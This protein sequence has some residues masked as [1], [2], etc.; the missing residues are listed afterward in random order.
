MHLKRWITG[1]VGAPLIVLLVSFGGPFLFAVV[2][3]ILCLLA[4]WEY[5]RIVFQDRDPSN[6]GLIP[7]SGFV[8][9]PF[10][11]WGSYVNSFKIVLG[12]L[13]INFIITALISLT[14]YRSDSSVS[15]MA[16]KQLLG[17]IY[18]PFFLSYFVWIRN[19]ANGISWIY[20][21]VLV[22]FCGD[23]GAFYI[24]SYFGRR[25]LS[26]TI[27]PN[28][29]IEGAVGGL[30]ANLGVGALV[31]H[32]FMP[33]LPWGLSLLFFLLI[34]IAGQMGDLFESKLKRG[35]NIKDSGTLL[36]GHGGILD[37]IDALLFAVPVAYLFKEYIF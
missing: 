9:G 35:G 6:Q 32:L 15:E 19:G 34:G 31:K 25:K 18:I 8:T 21:I 30:A 3:G 28:K 2:I 1:L 4:L 12:I 11:I 5:F 20:L 22:I 7:L 36:P 24:G 16:A 26:P 13:T 10:I 14:K 29:T 33:F 27:S 17:M 37:R 23:I